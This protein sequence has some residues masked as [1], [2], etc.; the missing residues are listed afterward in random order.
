MQSH[1]AIVDLLRIRGWLTA[2]QLGR[3]VGISQTYIRLQVE[4]EDI[5]SIPIGGVKRIYAQELIK[6][7]HK[8]RSKNPYVVGQAIIAANEYITNLDTTDMGD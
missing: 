4:S 5:E 6:V 2:G 3:L 8:Y 1:K 7:L